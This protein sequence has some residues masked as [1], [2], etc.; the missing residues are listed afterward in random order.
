MAAPITLASYALFVFLYYKPLGVLG[1]ALATFSIFAIS[2]VAMSWHLSKLLKGFSLSVLW[3]GVMRY[4][5]VATVCV[6][7]ASQ[8][9]K[10]MALPDILALCLH[11]CIGLGAYVSVLLI[12]R[13]ESLN[14]ILEK[15]GWRDA[16]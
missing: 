4:C 16:L 6:W 3:L 8:L 12:L 11:G 13:D 14:L 10:A 2:F 5:L 15:L 1:I 9:V 7:G